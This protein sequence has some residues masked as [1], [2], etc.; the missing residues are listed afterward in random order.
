[1]TTRMQ[2]RPTDE[3]RAEAFADRMVGAL[4]AASLVLQCSIGDQL[5][6]FDV[7]A[8]SDDATSE[9]IAQ[10]AGL[11]ERYVREWLAALT[12]A[13]VVEHDA[14]DRTYR[15][16]PEH[17]AVLTRAAGPDNL[18]RLCQYIPMLAEAEQLVV[19]AFRSGGGVPY[20]AFSRFHEVMAE[21]SAAVNDASLLDTILPLVPG[22]PER[23]TAGI[24]V[25]DFGCG[26]GHA[27]NLMA[28]AYPASRFVGYDF[29][30]EA[31]DRA[32]AEAAACGLPN[33]RFEVQDVAG[34]DRADAFDL[35]TAFDAIHD[36]AQPAQVLAAIARA[37]RPDGIFLMVD[38]TGSSEV[39]DNI[40]MPLATFLYTCSLLHCMP[41]S[42]GLDGVGL[43]TMWGRQTALRMLGEAGFVDV[44]VRAIETDPQNAYYV[45]TLG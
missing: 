44:A 20:S 23:L 34:V 10:A 18:A 41:V 15:L 17:A 16:P 37:L 24:D 11:Q 32:R 26:S 19:A 13:R 2:H 7:M 4:D 5:G 35:I 22:L 30:P 9:Q 43:G 3:Q 8:G 1:M 6:L 27:V 25:A 14:S 28:R 36:Q 42:L 39:A 29:S 33:A 38:I 21:D 45:C 12:V 40:D 31:I